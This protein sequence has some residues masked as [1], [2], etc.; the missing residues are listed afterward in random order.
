MK[1]EMREETLHSIRGN[2]VVRPTDVKH[3][4]EML[5]AEPTGTA[6]RC[7]TPHPPDWSSLQQHKKYVTAPE[8]RREEIPHRRN[9]IYLQS[10]GGKERWLTTDVY[11]LIWHEGVESF[12]FWWKNT[13]S[14]GSIVPKGFDQTQSVLCETLC[15]WWRMI[16]CVPDA[17]G[18]TIK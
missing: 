6:G 9:L 3:S 11:V 10:P 18:Y 15:V 4:A 8:W 5:L 13:L 17:E 12:L 1:M 7:S 2:Q 14:V 16:H